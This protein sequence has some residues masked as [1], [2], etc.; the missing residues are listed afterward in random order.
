MNTHPDKKQL[1]DILLGTADNE[2]SAAVSSHVDECRECSDTLESLKLIIQESDNSS[3]VPSESVRN[4]LFMGQKSY[5]P[6]YVRK[7]SFASGLKLLLRPVPL[8]A[9]AAVVI[10]AVMS[11]LYTNKEQVPVNVALKL[12]QHHGSIAYDGAVFD[13]N[14]AEI[15]PGH[16][17]TEAG[18]SVFLSLEPAISISIAENTDI[19]INSAQSVIENKTK[20]YIASFEMKSGSIMVSSDHSIIKKYTISTPHAVIEPLGTGF[21][22]STDSSSSKLSVFEGSVRVI[23][24]KG[25]EMI[26]NKGEGCEVNEDIEKTDINAEKAIESF[27]RLFY[28]TKEKQLPVPV[29]K[30]GQDTSVNENT[31]YGKEESGDAKD[32]GMRIQ[33]ETR[34]KEST[35]KE[36]RENKSELRNDSRQMQKEMKNNR[37]SG[38]GSQR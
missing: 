5:S 17:Q 3:I 34:E 36:L 30:S 11:V 1:V 12:T 31:D 20:K 29:K 28:D 32:T 13:K 38:K 25:R 15:N 23:A 6:A 21:I 8:A 19:I 16:I 10:I 9:A 26:L 14:A 24:L 4:R 2:T 35:A 37:R 33:D 18:S 27:N 7:G 22:L